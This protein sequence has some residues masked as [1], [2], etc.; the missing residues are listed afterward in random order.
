MK[1]KIIVIK[2]GINLEQPEFKE[3]YEKLKQIGFRTDFLDLSIKTKPEL[4]TNPIVFDDSKYE[5]YKIDDVS[6]LWLNGK[7]IGHQF[8]RMTKIRS[9]I[10]LGHNIGNYLDKEYLKSPGYR[11]KVLRVEYYCELENVELPIYKY[12]QDRT[13]GKLESEV[14][15]PY[16][17]QITIKKT[18]S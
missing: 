5:E 4:L 13:N 6:F 10:Q 1:D 3:Y 2:S 16:E 8:L 14:V 18:Q 11:K 17:K 9:K 7:I 12:F 15:I